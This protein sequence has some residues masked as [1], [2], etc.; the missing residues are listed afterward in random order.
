MGDLKSV[1]IR[2]LSAHNLTPGSTRQIIDP[3]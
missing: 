1:E 2:H 3:E